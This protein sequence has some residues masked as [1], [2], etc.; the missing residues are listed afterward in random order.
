MIEYPRWKLIAL[1]VV[2]LLGILY[3]MPNLFPQDSAVQISAGR[4]GVV[5]D[6]LKERVQGVLE[7]QKIA[8]S[9]IELDD[10]RLL[11]RVADPDVQIK[12]ADALRED[13]GSESY[14]V[15]LNL[16]SNVPGWLTA[17]YGKAMT[18]G[19]DLQGGVH[20]LMEVDQRATVQK[21]T[22]RYVEDLRTT[23]RD[24]R[25]LCRNVAPGQQGIVVTCRDE[26]QRDRAFAEISRDIPALALVNG[27]VSADA[28]TLVA[29]IKP[30][31]LKLASDNAIQQ[32]VATLRNRINSVGV[33]EPII[34]QQGSSRIV[35]QLPGVQ[36]TAL[37]K[38]ILGATATLE[39]RAVDTK[40]NPNEAAASGRAPPESRLYR[41]REG[42]P[43]LLS[44]RLI[45]SGDQLVDA[46]SSIDSQ[47][48]TPAVSV[49]LNAVGARKMLEF[50]NA[51]VG[52]GMAVVYVERIPEI[53]VVDGKEVRTARI[54]E[55]VIS[56]ANVRE[57]FGKNFQTTGLDSTQEASELALLLR[58][59]SLAAPVDIVE[60]RTIGPSQGKDN[61]QRGMKATVVGFAL[62]LLFMGIYYRVFGIIADIALIANT[63]LLTA[64]LSIAGVTLTMPGIAALLLTVGMAVDANVL[65]CERI[66]EELRAG[67]TPIAAIK[68]GYDKAWATIVDA[69]VTHLI[70]GIALL[71]LGSG[72]IRG[73]AFVLTFGIVTSVFTAVTV[74]YA[75]TYLVYGRRRRL[76][77][78]SI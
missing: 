46:N 1:A 20:F 73:F 36:D 33:A 29:T 9:R 32:N 55:E 18:L 10:G 62:V 43:V 6:A 72:P 14:I 27:P 39:Y 52:N 12:A 75:I 53:K 4:G 47:S 26:E 51:N 8:F 77:T 74:S 71:A 19:L 41:T 60:E 50:T 63:L 15:A 59:G 35:V 22:E 61:I 67:N 38:K 64:I 40:N 44:K 3:A 45:V 30:A 16:A 31:E 65:I 70:S 34:Q 66:R 57:P 68:A 21:Q 37:A 58:A 23:L 28:Y 7:K 49:T 17:I 24:K 54:K 76:Q 42:Q 69:N 56:V 13:L 78:L 48:G 2:M 11:V 5:D 25:I